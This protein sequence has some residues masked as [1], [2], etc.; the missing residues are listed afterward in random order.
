MQRNS[1]QLLAKGFR[2]VVFDECHF[3]KSNTSK[4]AQAA[5]PII[6]VRLAGKSAPL[7]QNP[8]VGTASHRER[9]HSRRMYNISRKANYGTCMS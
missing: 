8:G 2:V 5:V 3:L 7:I 4:R 9:F 6:K 1:K